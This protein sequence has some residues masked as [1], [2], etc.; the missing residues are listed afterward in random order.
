[1]DSFDS[2]DTL[3]RLIKYA[4][5]SEYGEQRRGSGDAFQRLQTWALHR[6]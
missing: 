6:D 5:D 2:A 3:H 1:M 4:L